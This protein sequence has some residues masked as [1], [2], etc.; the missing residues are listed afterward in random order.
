MHPVYTDEGSFLKS[1][2]SISPQS[3]G[4]ATVTGAGVATLVGPGFD[5]QSCQLALFIGAVTGT[6]GTVSIVGQLQDSPDGSTSWAN[7]GAAMPTLATAL[8]AG[9]IL[10]SQNQQIRGSRGFLRLTAA[11]TLVT[12]TAVL[13]GGVIVLG[14]ASEDPAV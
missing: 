10:V 1:V 14:G 12:F 6:P 4:S 3:T 2:L 9:N 5:Y 13:V 8:N 11:V 7:F